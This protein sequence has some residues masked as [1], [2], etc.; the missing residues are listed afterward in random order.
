[1]RSFTDRIKVT[2]EPPAQPVQTVRASVPCK[3]AFLDAVKQEVLGGAQTMMGSIVTPPG[4]DLVSNSL[5][6]PEYKFYL[7][8][9][10]GVGITYMVPLSEK[11]G[12]RFRYYVVQIF[13]D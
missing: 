8:S 10:T 2:R 6:M 3:F 9:P 13:D 4:I 12:R 5:V 7:L 11:W 1:M